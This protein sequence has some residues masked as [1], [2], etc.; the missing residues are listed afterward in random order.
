MTKSLYAQYIEERAN[1][2]ILETEIGFATFSYGP[3]HVYLEDVYIVPEHRNLKNASKFAD[4]VALIAKEQGKKQL[5]SSVCPQANGST[6]SLKVLLGY[7]FELL[8]SDNNLIYFV[9]DI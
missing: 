2:Y 3:E 6:T 7:G 5:I 8:N 4:E 9:K 1:K